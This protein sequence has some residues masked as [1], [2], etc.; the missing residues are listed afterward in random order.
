MG[1]R[2]LDAGAD[3]GILATASTL[4]GMFTEAAL[5]MYSMAA[6]LREVETSQ[7]VKVE[8]G[9]HSL[10]GLLVAWLNE[11]V[12]MMDARGFVASRVEVTSLD[13]EGFHIGAVLAGE[14]LGSDR[15]GQGLL[16]KAATYH[17]LWIGKNDGLWSARVTFDI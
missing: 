9:S 3:A 14:E 16:I 12:Y 1:Y 13:P 6:D 7:L 17:D 15:F 8:V 5:G 10:D 4:E 11:L 2:M